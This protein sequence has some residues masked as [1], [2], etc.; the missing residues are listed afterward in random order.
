MLIYAW[1]RVKR[2]IPFFPF[3]KFINGLFYIFFWSLMSRQVEKNCSF[4]AAVCKMYSIFH[5]H[6]VAFTLV[7]PRS[8]QF[9]FWFHFVENFINSLS[10]HF[11]S[12]L[13]HVPTSS[14][15]HSHF[16]VCSTL[17]GRFWNYKIINSL[18]DRLYMWFF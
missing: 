11:H 13:V 8:I 2:E 14:N 17:Y 16:C 1:N 5:Q 7:Q 6:L 10:K 12:L 4:H 9:W 18:V 15:I 3:G